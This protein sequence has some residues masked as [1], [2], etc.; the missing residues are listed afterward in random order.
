MAKSSG[1]NR[2]PVTCVE[3]QPFVEQHSLYSDE[4]R[5]FSKGTRK[6]SQTR[7]FGKGS[8]QEVDEDKMRQRRARNEGSD[9]QRLSNRTDLPLPGIAQLPGQKQQRRLQHRSLALRSTRVH[10]LFRYFS[11]C[12]SVLFY[13]FSSS[14]QSVCLPRKEDI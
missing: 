11:H 4:P 6:L 5:H 13:L 1:L 10:D 9:R 8:S 14:S 12:V 3:T 2:N 7:T